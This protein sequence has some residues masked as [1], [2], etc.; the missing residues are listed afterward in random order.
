M[1]F[2]VE[3]MISLSMAYKVIVASKLSLDVKS[4]TGFEHEGFPSFLH[5]D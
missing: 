2:P 1:D 5:W 4:E 3:N